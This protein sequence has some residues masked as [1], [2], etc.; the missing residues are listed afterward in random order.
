VA[1]ITEPVNAFNAV[2]SQSNQI[3][4]HVF[5]IPPDSR[6][7]VDYVSARGVVP[8]GESVSGIFINVPVVHFFMV[9]AQGADIFGKSVFT[10]AQDLRI[11]LGPFADPRNVVVRMER[12]AFGTSANFAVTLAGTLVN[13]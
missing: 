9:L 3:D 8:P 6:L 10:T 11:E 2:T 4:N 5:T 1:N 7:V 13:P 12:T